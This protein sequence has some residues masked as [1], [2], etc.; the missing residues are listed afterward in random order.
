MKRQIQ[1]KIWFKRKNIS[2]IKTK[3]ERI[4]EW[5]NMTDIA[6][7][8]IGD[9]KKWK[10]LKLRKKWTWYKGLKRKWQML[11]LGKDDVTCRE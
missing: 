9:G 11:K 5:I 1:E 3:L 2:E 7:E 6:L 8:A 10:I 4:H